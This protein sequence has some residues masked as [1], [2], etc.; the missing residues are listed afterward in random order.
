MGKAYSSD[1]RDRIVSDIALGR[2][3]RSA[4]PPF[5]GEPELCR[6]AGAARSCDGI[7][8]PMN[9]TAFETYV[10]TQLAPTINPGDVMIL[11]NL[12]SHKSEKAK[13]IFKARG[14]WFLFTPPCP[15]SAPMAQI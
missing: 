5:W 15:P 13:A 12:S 14:A 11:D 7:D 3:R 10:E 6:E 2:S 4:F 1:L 9:R 8:C